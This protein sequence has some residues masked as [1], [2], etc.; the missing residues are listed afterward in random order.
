MPDHGTKVWCLR[1]FYIL[2]LLQNSLS[3]PHTAIAVFFG[4]IIRACRKCVLSPEE[5]ANIQNCNE[6]SRRYL[7]SYTGS[8][9]SQTRRDL[10]DVSE[11][12]DDMLI[13]G[14]YD[15]LTEHFNSTGRFDKFELLGKR[16]SFA[17]ASR[18]KYS[19]RPFDDTGSTGL[20]IALPL[21]IFALIPPK[22]RQSLLISLFRSHGMWRN[23]RGLCRRL[24]AAIRRSTDQLDQ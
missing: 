15:A 1:K 10:K 23:P 7:I 8:I 5:E 20:V 12:E 13:G 14:K 19:N 24:D 9:R 4:F 11:H 17:A 21:T 3:L 2:V 18:G 16:S 22:R 6:E